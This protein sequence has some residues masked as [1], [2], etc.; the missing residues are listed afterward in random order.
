MYAKVI[1]IHLCYKS[2]PVCVEQE[3]VYRGIAGSDEYTTHTH[4]R[5]QL[6]CPGD[7]NLGE[8]MDDE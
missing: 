7:L 6:W 1:M 3:D 5:T 4:T 8:V 2:E